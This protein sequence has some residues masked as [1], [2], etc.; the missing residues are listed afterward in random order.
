MLNLIGRRL[1][2]R[3]FNRPI[4]VIGTGRSGTSVLLQALGRHPLIVDLPGEA[5]FLTSIGYSAF[6]F[7]NHPDSEYYRDSLKVTKDYFFHQLRRL[8]FE[9]AAGPH[10][11]LKLFAGGL[12][13]RRRSPLGRR[14][15]AAKTFPEDESTRGW[16]SLY[17]E[18]KLIYIVRNGCD[19]VHSMTKY[20]GFSQQDFRHHCINWARDVEK[21]RYLTASPNAIVV[22]Q[23]ELL[24]EPPT[25]FTRLFDF[26][27]LSDDPAPAEFTGTTLIHP[28]DQQTQ[29][30]FDPK[31][32]LKLR[33]PPY[34]DWSAE[35]KAIFKEICEPGMAELGY[36]VPF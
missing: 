2:A 25:L 35:Q 16:M 15:W 8:G 10:F 36:E 32:E 19:V 18:A 1:T 12:L 34:Q 17:P 27:E 7:E 3:F 4:L 14:C 23:E 6:L 24:N 11:G 22:R 9:T 21:Y 20:A 13:G 31:A 29:T 28:L 5:P 26:L 33:Q 30:D